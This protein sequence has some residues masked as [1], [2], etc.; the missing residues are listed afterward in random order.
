MSLNNTDLISDL[1]SAPVEPHTDPRSVDM[2]IKEYINTRDALTEARDAYTLIE[3]SYKDILASLSMRLREMADEQ[4]VDSFN[5]RG[6]GTAYRNIKTSYRV[7]DWESYIAWVKETDNFQCL[8]KRV[9]KLNV[10]AVHK[11]TSAIPPGLEYVAEQEFSV[12]ISPS[13]SKD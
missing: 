12:R 3:K 13:S 11:A 5:V 7:R 10:V 9:A 8:E 6:V 4:G 1:F 2:L